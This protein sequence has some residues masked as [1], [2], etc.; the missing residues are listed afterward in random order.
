MGMRLSQPS[1]V[2]PAGTGVRDHDP[3]LAKKAGGEKDQASMSR[4]E[5]R[6]AESE[7]QLGGHSCAGPGY[8][9]SL[10]GIHIQ[11]RAREQRPEIGL[12]LECPCGPST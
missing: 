2:K 10:S 1:T 9:S 11:M 12:H 7:E 6:C 5:V 4:E 3:L 8:R